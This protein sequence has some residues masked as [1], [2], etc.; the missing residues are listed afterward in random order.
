MEIPVT[1]LRNFYELLKLFSTDTQTQIL[2]DLNRGNNYEN[3]IKIYEDS[4][5]HFKKY[6]CIDP[7][8]GRSKRKL[9]PIN[10]QHNIKEIEKIVFLE[11]DSST[12]NLER[13]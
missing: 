4:K 9:L 3:L 11:L 12:F 10:L 13:I 7:F 2:K 1:K 5:V 8:I 6:C